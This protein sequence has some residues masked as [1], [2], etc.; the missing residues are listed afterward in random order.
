VTFRALVVATALT[1]AMTAPAHAGILP[2]A[3][4]AELAQ[5]L[6]EAQAEQDVCY[7]WSVGNNF[8]ISG[9]IGSGSGGPGTAVDRA[10]CTRGFVELG[11]NIDYACDSCESED[12]A[13]VTIESNL[14]NPPT[15][16]DLEALGLKAGALTGDSDDT[17]LVNMVN[18]LPLLVADRGNA[19]Y[20]EYEQT[21]TVPAT[22]R[23]TNKPGS[24]FMR[25]SWIQL[26]LFGGLILGGPGFYL[27]KRSQRPPPP[28]EHDALYVPPH[29]RT[30]APPPEPSSAPP[31]EPPAAPWPEQAGDPPPEP[32][33]APPPEPERPSN[34]PQAT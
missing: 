29:V 5:S 12:S 18:A 16:Q 13:R 30:S 6:A 14:P 34:P 4:A 17:T 10:A 23:A 19:P 9:D 32:A 8:D 25:D 28:Q 33:S 11:G 3:D 2:D 7:G 21:K 24:D 27:Y 1:F 15:V 22:D 31:P 26:V 20:L